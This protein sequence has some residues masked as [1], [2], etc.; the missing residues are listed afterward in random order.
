MTAKA[1]KRKG[2]TWN[3]RTKKCNRTYAINYVQ[4][5]PWGGG[6]RVYIK[7]ETLEKAKEQFN[8]KYTGKG[9]HPRR[10]TDAWWYR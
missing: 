9:Y 1:C 3:P 6:G 7:D 10:I 4:P 5:S 2:G 8:E